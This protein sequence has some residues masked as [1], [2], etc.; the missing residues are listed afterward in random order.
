MSSFDR[1]L[2]AG[3]AH[4]AH[5]L[6]RLLSAVRT[7]AP[8]AYQTIE[9]RCAAMPI[10]ALLDEH[11]DW[12]NTDDGTQLIADI[13]TALELADIE[14]APANDDSIEPVRSCADCAALSTADIFGCAGWT[15]RQTPTH[16]RD[17]CPACAG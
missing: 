15:V 17:I 9:P 5:V 2:A 11:A 4:P 13:F 1:A 10:E 14:G 7:L 8:V 3:P 16:V 12:W 6:P